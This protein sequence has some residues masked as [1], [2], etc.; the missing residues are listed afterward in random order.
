MKSQSSGQPKNYA[1][2]LFSTLYPLSPIIFTTANVVAFVLLCN[3]SFNFHCY[4]QR[5][6]MHT[7]KSAWKW[8]CNL[9]WLLA[10][11]IRKG[12]HLCKPASLDCLISKDRVSYNYGYL[13]HAPEAILLLSVGTLLLMK[14]CLNQAK[15]VW[16][17]Q[18]LAI[19]S[20]L[21]V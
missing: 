5:E 11:K 9:S 15:I 16:R 1:K 20:L 17:K 2:A 12:I 10:R 14:N 13:F 4:T 3:S 19:W 18:C 8:R 21:E 6:A 7:Q